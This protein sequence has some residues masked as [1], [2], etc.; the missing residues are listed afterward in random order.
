[1]IKKI[2]L[3]IFL[4]LL[5]SVPVWSSE[6]QTLVREL[7]QSI[8]AVK[9]LSQEVGN[10]DAF[11]GRDPMRP[12]VDAGGSLISMDYGKEVAELKVEGIVS[13]SPG[14]YMAL[15]NNRLYQQGSYLGDTQLVEIRH[16]GVFIKKDSSVIFLPLYSGS[17]QTD[18]SSEQ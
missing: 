3:T 8:E 5:Y 12:L 9:R 2:F 6:A 17:F 4:G 1:M 11:S 16:D 7:S 10:Y 18:A 15:I 13:S 14:A